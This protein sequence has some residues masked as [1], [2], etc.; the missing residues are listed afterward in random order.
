MAG[1]PKSKKKSRKAQKKADRGT[2]LPLRG[3][4]TAEEAALLELW[5]PKYLLLK[6]A[7]GNKFVGF[8][9]PLFEEYF[10]VRP[11][12]PLTPKDIANGVDQGDHRG[13]R[14][15]T[16]KQLIVIS[17]LENGR[18]ALLY[19][20]KESKPRVLSTYH[21]Y[22]TMNKEHISPVITQEWVDSILLERYTDEEKAM[23]V[24][25][26]PIAFRNTTLKHLLQAEPPSVQAEVDAWWWAKQ[27]AGVKGDNEADEETARFEKAGQY[28]QAQQALGPT[29]Q[30]ILQNIEE[31]TGLIGL[32]TVVGPGCSIDARSGEIASFTTSSPPFKK[33]ASEA[34]FG[35][36]RA[37]GRCGSARLPT[38]NAPERDIVTGNAPH[39]V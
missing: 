3:T 17:E 38:S 7:H 39:T 20:S 28:H 4:F 16:V 26:V 35:A 37:E 32:F 23:P 30:R 11:L 33:G 31:Q 6:R 34:A 8:W 12:P 19:L 9:E 24:P 1:E 10:R 25:Q 13:E 36:L 2:S 18:R 27:T 22:G 5:L 21:A 15:A 29:I 14:M